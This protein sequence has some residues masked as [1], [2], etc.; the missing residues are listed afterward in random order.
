ML[1][2]CYGSALMQQLW[3]PNCTHK[4]QVQNAIKTCHVLNRS[5]ARQDCCCNGSIA[6]GW[7]VVRCC[8]CN[9]K[10]TTQ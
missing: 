6:I 8:N 7:T 1:Q 9:E 5:K 2:T 3:K 4:Y 10:I